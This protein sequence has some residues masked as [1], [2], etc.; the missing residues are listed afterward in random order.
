AMRL[1]DR[2]DLTTFAATRIAARRAYEMARITRKELEVVEL[3]DA[4][5]P[6]ALID[7]EDLGVC[8]P[9]EAGNWFAQGWVAPDGRLPVNPSGGVLGRGHPS[10]PPGSPRSRRWRASS[11]ARPGRERFR[12]FPGSGSPSRSAEWLPT[13]S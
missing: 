2:V 12:A 5:A 10:A 4:F 7:L 6:F 11:G 8:G 13:T 3:H 9:G 1:I